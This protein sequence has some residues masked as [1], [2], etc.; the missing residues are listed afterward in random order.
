[1]YVFLSSRHTTTLFMS[2]TFTGSKHQSPSS[3]TNH[4]APFLILLHR[5][6]LHH[7]HHS[8]NYIVTDAKF[9]SSPFC[10][11]DS[12]LAPISVLYWHFCIMN[13]TWIWNCW[14][15]TTLPVCTPIAPVVQSL[16]SSSPNVLVQTEYQ[17][18]RSS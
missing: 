18:F 4:A 3:N 17:N 14:I 8:D 9:L 6:L 7:F 1:M 16:C 2:S 10:T 15:V 12:A 5:L 11:P 13:C